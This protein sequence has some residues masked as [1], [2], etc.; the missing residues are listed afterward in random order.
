MNKQIPFL[1]LR[2]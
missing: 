2:S 1:E